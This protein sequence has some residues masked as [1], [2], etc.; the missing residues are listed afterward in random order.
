MK[1]EFASSSAASVGAPPEPCEGDGEHVYYHE[2]YEEHGKH[3]FVCVEGA[4]M[5][6]SVGGRAWRWP[7]ERRGRRPSGFG[8]ARGGLVV[9]LELGVLGDELGH[10]L[11]HQYHHVGDVDPLG[12]C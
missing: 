2:E 8:Y 5:P 1:A 4:G 6:R 9:D 10:G 7:P 11:F 12:G 3:G